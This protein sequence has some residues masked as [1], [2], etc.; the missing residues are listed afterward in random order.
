[1][2]S[3]ETYSDEGYS[4]ETAALN[5][6][7][8]VVQNAEGMTVL[9]ILGPKGGVLATAW[10][11]EKQAAQVATAVMKSYRSGHTPG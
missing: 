9:S 4:S 3:S 6:K 10:L 8:V 2:Y 5:G 1:M 7:T 11:A